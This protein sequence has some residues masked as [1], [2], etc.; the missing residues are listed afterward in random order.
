MPEC[1]GFDVL[2]RLGAHLTAEV[3]FVT[4]YDQH[5]VHAFEAGALDYILKPF[6]DERFDVTLR[7]VKSRIAVRDAIPREQRLFVKGNRQFSVVAI[8]E[9]DWIEAA[10]YYA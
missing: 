3:V 2:D 9:I 4:A 7:R 1:D 10:D 8:R 5:A 6:T